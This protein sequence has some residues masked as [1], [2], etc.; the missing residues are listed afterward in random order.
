MANTPR[1]D[2][3]SVGT[4]TAFCVPSQD[5]VATLKSLGL[6]PADW[7]PKRRSDDGPTI[8]NDRR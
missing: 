3:I 2:M 8:E 4:S 6:L 7:R 5:F 1:V